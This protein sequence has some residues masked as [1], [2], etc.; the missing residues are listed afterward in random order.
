MSRRTIP[1]AQGDVPAYLAAPRGEG[2]WPA[3]VVI[4]DVLGMSHDVERQADW[5]AREG[6]LAA[7]PDLFHWGRK[8]TCLRSIMRDVNRR[9]GRAFEEIDAVRAWLSEQ[10]ACTGQVGVI[11]FCLGGG[12]A[13]L[14]AP[15]HGYA[16][17]SVNYGTVP[18]DA[19][20][21]LAGA[22]PVVGSFGGRDRTLRGAAGRLEGALTANHVAHDVREYPDAGHS[23]MNDHDPA[24][25]PALF[26]L[27]R[28]LIGGGYAPGP[29]EDSRRRIVSFFD[30]HLKR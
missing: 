20:S 9:R 3:V 6:Y 17:S 19:R 24:D 10:Q 28:N 1:C 26:V 14:L 22:C 30:T 29:A 12:F 13:L 11:G 7:A 15:G 16:A 23:F 27:M 4:H 18:K 21:L 25:T 5:L 2:P 8:M